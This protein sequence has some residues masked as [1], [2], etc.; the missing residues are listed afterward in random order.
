[1][2]F[3][4]FIISVKSQILL[5]FLLSN[6]QVVFPGLEDWGHHPAGPAAETQPAAGADGGGAGPHPAG[7]Q[8]P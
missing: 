2:L 8:D 4:D 5:T 6:P 3:S 7:G 1:M